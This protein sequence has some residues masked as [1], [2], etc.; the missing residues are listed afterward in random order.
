VGSGDG[1]YWQAVETEDPI[2]RVSLGMAYRSNGVLLSEAAWG[3]MDDN[4]VHGASAAKD[5]LSLHL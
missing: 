4:V 5:L 3:P 2:L 1:C